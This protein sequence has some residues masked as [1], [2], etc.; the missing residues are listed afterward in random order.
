MMADR[1][2]LFAVILIMMTALRYVTS[3]GSEILIGLY[4]SLEVLRAGKPQRKSRVRK[5][6]QRSL[7]RI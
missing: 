2:L 6:R 5:N 3:I 7:R 4:I 1:I